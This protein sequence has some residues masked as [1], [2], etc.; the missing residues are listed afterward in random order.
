MNLLAQDSTHHTMACCLSRSSK[1]ALAAAGHQL[2]CSPSCAALPACRR[3]LKLLMAVQAASLGHLGHQLEAVPLLYVI[4]YQLGD[5]LML[6]DNALTPAGKGM[7]RDSALHGVA[8]V[9]K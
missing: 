4:L 3:R 7:A 2:C 1:A 9:P 5:H 8:E 6:L